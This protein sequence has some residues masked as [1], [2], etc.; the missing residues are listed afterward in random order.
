MLERCA[1]RHGNVHSA[2]G[3]R[4]VLDPVIAR[5]AARDLG[6]RFFRADAAYA[7]PV[8][9]ER[10]KRPVGRPSVTEVKRF[11][12]DFEYRAASWDKPRRVVAKI[13]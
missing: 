4:D 7:I 2:G 12:E 11:F 1:L 5:Y 9:Y 3:W 13:Q 10:L 6:G 8:I